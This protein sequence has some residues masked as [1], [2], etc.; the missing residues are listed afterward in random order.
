MEIVFSYI[1][2]N[3]VVGILVKIQ[4]QPTHQILNGKKDGIG[5]ETE[6]NVFICIVQN[7]AILKF[8][9]SLIIKKLLLINNK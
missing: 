2:Q 3:R 1:V 9:R 6:D 7:R 5:I 8:A 4:M